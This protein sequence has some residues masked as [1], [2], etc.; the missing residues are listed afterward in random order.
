M[1]L[2]N[3]GIT[4]SPFLAMCLREIQ[5]FLANFNIDMKASYVPSKEN[6]LADLCSRAFNND[7][8][9]KKFNKLLEDGDLILDI[10]HYD[11]LEFQCTW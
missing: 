8:F 2:L 1:A 5:F 6:H 9:H 7:E 10:L 3:Y 4:K 11:K